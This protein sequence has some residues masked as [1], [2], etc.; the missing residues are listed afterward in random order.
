MK[1]EEGTH[2]AWLYNVLQ[3]AKAEV[4]VCDL[5]RNRLLQD[6]NESDQVD[7]RKLA[8]LL[9]AGL[10]SPV[11]HGEHSTPDLKELVRSYEYLVEHSTRLI[12]RLKAFYRGRAISCAGADVYKLQRRERWLAKLPELGARVRAER[13]YSELDHLARLCREARRSLNRVPPAPGREGAAQGADA[14]HRPHRTTAR[15]CLQPASL[16]EQAAVLG[17]LRTGGGDEVERRLPP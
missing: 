5:R 14:R 3:R 12:N 10:L 15:Q 13:L 17:L 6:G 16:P 8:Q 1:F 4:I 2:A 11:Y 9:P 7:A